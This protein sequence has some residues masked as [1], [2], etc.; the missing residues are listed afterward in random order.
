MDVIQGLES[1]ADHFLTKPYEA[2]DLVARVNNILE[3]HRLRN[4]GL[5]DANEIVF[6]GRRFA[7]TSD[8]EQILSLLVS[9][10]EDTVR[11]NRQLQQSQ[12]ELAETLE[13]L[14]EANQELEAFS[15]SVSHDLRAPLRSILGFSQALQRSY[16]EGLDG[17]AYLD[18]ICGAAHRMSELID[19][20]LKLSQV[21]RAELNFRPVDLSELAREVVEELRARDSESQ[22]QVQVTIQ[23]RLICHGDESL[24]RVVMENLLGNAWKFTRDVQ[25]ADIRLEARQE[26]GQ[27]VFQLRDNG[28]GFDPDYAS[29]LFAPFQRLHRADEF[30]GTGIG[31]AIVGRIIHRHNGRIYAEGAVN[32]G[33]TIHFSLSPATLNLT[34]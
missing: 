5:Q 11:K 2:A 27:R 20:L 29:K 34:T 23:D 32:R 28:A 9:T 19:D 31:L 13:K 25:P 12:A 6:L 33:A 17:R 30:P 8:K 1:G 24:L 18:R 4:G 7:I 15:Y 26:G 14:K 3:T 22:R 21:T 16:P 10:F